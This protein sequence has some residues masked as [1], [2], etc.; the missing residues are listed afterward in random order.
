M[1]VIVGKLSEFFF[2][3]T[4][5]VRSL[6]IFG[7]LVFFLTSCVIEKGVLEHVRV[8]EDDFGVTA[9]VALDD[10]CVEDDDVEDVL[11]SLVDDV[12]VGLFFF[13]FE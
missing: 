9:E 11:G 3:T 8:E 4:F 5:V 6:L 12:S 10:V 7:T 1:F 13:F 2:I